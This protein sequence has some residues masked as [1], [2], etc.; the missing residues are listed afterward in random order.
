MLELIEQLQQL[1][2]TIYIKI[3]P[4]KKFESFSQ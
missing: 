2:S 4:E 1:W 3:A